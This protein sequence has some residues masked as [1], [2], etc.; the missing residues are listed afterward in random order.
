M[1][2]S[3]GTIARLL[4]WV[5]AGR[6]PAVRRWAGLKWTACLR[7]PVLDFIKLQQPGERFVAFQRGLLDEQARALGLV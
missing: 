7:D 3:A 1:A 6:R 4:A 2:L 5:R